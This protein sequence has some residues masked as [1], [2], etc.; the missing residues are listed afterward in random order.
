MG[1]T[2]L[3]FNMNF[4]EITKGQRTIGG[5]VRQVS[6]KCVCKKARQIKIIE[7]Q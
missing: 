1:V 3:N 7:F 6:R 4:L 2:Y 5:G